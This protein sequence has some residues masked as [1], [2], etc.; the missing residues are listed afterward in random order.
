MIQTFAVSEADFIS[1]YMFHKKISCFK[2][3]LPDRCA[4]TLSKTFCSPCSRA[5]CINEYQLMAGPLNTAETRD[6]RRP[7]KH[8]GLRNDLA[9]DLNTKL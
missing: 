3:Y 1:T 2:I 7:F 9:L 5:S 6:K 8:L 4:R